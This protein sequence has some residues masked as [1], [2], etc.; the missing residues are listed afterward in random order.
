MKTCFYLGL[1]ALLIALFLSACVSRPKV[2]ADI[3]QHET[4][5]FEMCEANPELINFGIYRVIGEDDE[6]FIPYCSPEITDYLA[7]HQRQA[8]PILRDATR[9]R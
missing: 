1:V 5:S 7:I 6:E 8:E 2:T 9:P 4:I 3:Y